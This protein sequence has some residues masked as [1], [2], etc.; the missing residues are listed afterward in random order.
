[1]L[2]TSGSTGK[3]KG[4][5]HSTAGYLLHAALTG[6]DVDALSPRDALDQLYALKA[7][8]QLTHLDADGG[9]GLRIIVR[10]LAHQVATD[11]ILL[12]MPSRAS[13][14]FRTSR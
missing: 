10:P 4:V 9:I 7:L 2:Y 14:C 3:P 8:A 5:V 1:M 11:G 12:Q 13:Y 6:L